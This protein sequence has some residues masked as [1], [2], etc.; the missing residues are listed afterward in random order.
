[1]ERVW[2][3]LKGIEPSKFQGQFSG[4]GQDKLGFNA[5]IGRQ[6][7]SNLAAA[8]IIMSLQDD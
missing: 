6:S 5:S 3:K 8:S 7:K 1:M 4:F 2:L